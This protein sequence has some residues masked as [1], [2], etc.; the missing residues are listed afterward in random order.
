MQYINWLIISITYNESTK[1]DDTHD[2]DDT[3]DIIFNSIFRAFSSSTRRSILKHLSQREISRKELSILIGT[4]KENII[5]HCDI[6]I[7]CG[8]VTSEIRTYADNITD[9]RYNT[10]YRLKNRKIFELLEKVEKDIE[11]T[12]LKYK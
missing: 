10:F 1:I 7:G 11:E 5:K 8:L 12:F 9:I 6:L 4:S 3:V 2:K